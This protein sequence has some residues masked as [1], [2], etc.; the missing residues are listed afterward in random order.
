[1]VNAID[2]LAAVER[3]PRSVDITAACHEDGAVAIRV[4]DSG[5]GVP[6]DIAARLFQ[7][8]A[9]GKADGM[10]LGLAIS[11][12][13][14]EAH[15]GTLTMVRGNGPVACFEIVLPRMPESDTPRD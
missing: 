9:T 1:L 13:L 11:R 3:G 6:A 5:P 7:P 15:G 12:T 14:V 8:F 4:C 2:A 10:G